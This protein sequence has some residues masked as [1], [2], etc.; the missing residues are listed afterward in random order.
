MP[1]QDLVEYFNDRLEWEHHAN[2]RPFFFKDDRVY[3]LFGPVRVAT[4]FQTIHTVEPTPLIVGQWAQ[5]QVTTEEIPHLQSHELELLLS[6]PSSQAIHPD[7]I[8]DFDRLAR[9]VHMLNFLTVSH[10][11]GFLQLDVDPRHVLGVKRDHG[12]YFQEVIVKCGLQPENIAINLKV[13]PVYA[14][15]F[16][17]LLHGLEN[18]RHRGYKI[19]LQLPGLTPSLA[20]LV[21]QLQPDWMS[22]PVTSDEARDNTLLPSVPALALAVDNQGLAQVAQDKG[23]AYATGRYDLSQGLYARTG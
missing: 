13:S 17:N 3:G 8:V 14:R 22:L 23:F 10:T 9:T 16:R 4:N 1:I 6:L 19:G 12:A 15:Y 21:E 7:S 2:F 11:A 20:A 5:L 18:Y